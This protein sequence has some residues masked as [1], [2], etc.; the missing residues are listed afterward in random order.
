MKKL[1]KEVILND[2]DGLVS[3][4]EILN[5]CGGLKFYIDYCE[6]TTH[7]IY[8]I[9]SYESRVFQKMVEKFRRKTDEFGVV[10]DFDGDLPVEELDN[11]YIC[12]HS[13]MP[14]FRGLWLE[15][16][17]DFL[18]AECNYTQSLMLDKICLEIEKKYID[19]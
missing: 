16:G 1:Y 19:K 15:R 4:C 6:Q 11:L 13:V 17:E 5:E 7:I 3:Y 14:L 18:K 2:Y 12:L 10:Y 9:N 8:E